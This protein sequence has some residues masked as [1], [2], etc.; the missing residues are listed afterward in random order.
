M[1]SAE[2]IRFLILRTIGNFLILASLYA[3]VATFGPV[4][5]QEGVY[6]YNELRGVRYVVP[7]E[8]ATTYTLNPSQS[9]SRQGVVTKLLTKDPNVRLL[10]PVDTVFSVI[11]PRIGASARVIP[12]VDPGEESEYLEALNQGVAH[13]AGTGYPGGREGNRNVYLFAHSTDYFFRVPQYNAIFYLLKELE[14]GD[15]IDVFYQGKRYIYAVTEKKIVG[16]KEVSYLTTPTSEEQLT[17]QTCWPP[18][19]TLKRLL[20]I[21]KPRVAMEA[22]AENIT[23]FAKLM[24]RTQ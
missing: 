12:D 20:V 10:T 15:E 18:G 6:R 24:G 19:T 22:S 4:F 5:W 2:K 1:K 8:E 14:S 13:A 3:M 9:E 11:I 21:A 16:A 23:S 17:L 7:E